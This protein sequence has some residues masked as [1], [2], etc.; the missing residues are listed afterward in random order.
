MSQSVLESVDN[1]LSSAM[2]QHEGVVSEQGSVDD[3]ADAALAKNYSLDG[4]NIRGRIPLEKI[5]TA[6]RRFRNGERRANVDAPRLTILFSGPPGCG[7]TQ[8]ARYI[9]SEV[10]APLHCVRASDILGKYIGE[11]EK[12][13]AKAFSD[14]K[15]KNAILFIDEIDGII[16]DRGG[17]FHSWEITAVEQCLQEL[18][19]FQGVVIGATNFMKNLDKAVLRRFTFKIEMDFL[20][21]DGKATFFRRYFNTSLTEAERDRLDSID[22]LC[23]GDFRTVYEV[24]FYTSDSDSNLERLDALEEEAKAK[25]TG[26]AK[27]GF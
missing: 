27:I 10:Q 26:H 2:K 25:R 11:T 18:E 7:K 20:S 6:V 17:A 15:K 24:L 3:N 21:S 19:R 8:L 12:G 4:L 5:V 9:A 23:P 22:N 1:L 13:I 14:A 16:S